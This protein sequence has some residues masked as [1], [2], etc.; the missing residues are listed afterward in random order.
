MRPIGRITVIKMSTQLADH[1]SLAERGLMARAV[2][3]LVMTMM[4]ANLFSGCMRTETQR[5]IGTSSSEPT[6]QNASSPSLPANQSSDTVD[7]NH[8]VGWIHGECLGIKNA[9]I[10]P[11]TVVHVIS[12]EKPQSVRK[13]AIIG[14]ATSGN[15]CPALLPDRMKVNQR[16]GR[17][18][19]RLDL[20]TGTDFMAIG[21][22]DLKVKMISADG[23]IRID[24]TRDGTAAIAASCQT[25]EGVRFYLAPGDPSGQGRLWSD[26]YYL[27]YDTKP[28]CRD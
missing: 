21:V 28:T 26:Y 11:G 4:C 24:L 6:P 1:G 22:I 13:A 15:E 14:G 25:G 10:H 17:F 2:V 23:T 18:F 7:F 3:V 5:G 8:Y 19:Y 27:G 20:P 16:K 12:L 9:D